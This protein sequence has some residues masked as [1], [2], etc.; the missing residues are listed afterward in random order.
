MRTTLLFLITMGSPWGTLLADAAGQ[1]GRKNIVLIAGIKS[2]GPEGNGIHDY[3]WSARLIRT[4]L[5]NSNVRHKVN[6]SMHLAGWPQ[7]ERL[8]HNA[9]AMMIIS[10]GRDGDIGREAPHLTTPERVRLVEAMVKRVCGVA[11]FH[12]STFAPDALGEK[13]IDWYGGYFDWETDGKRAWY[14]DITTIQAEVSPASGQHPVLRGVKPFTIREEFYYDIR[15]RPGDDGWVPVWSVKALPATKSQ[16]DV[17]AWA[18]ERESGSRGFAT[19]CGHFYANWQDANFR[20]TILN[21]LA[22]SAHVPIPDDGVESEFFSHAQIA[23][24]LREPDLVDVT[25]S[26]AGTADEDVYANEPYWYKPGHPLKPAEARAI[27]VL[28]G[29]EV[30]KV[31]TVPDEWGS[32]TAITVD[33]RG[34]LICAAQHEPGLYRLMSSDAGERSSP[35][36]FEKLKGVAQRMGWSHGLLSAFDSLYVTV[37]EGNDVVSGG[38][39]RLRDTD[40]DD[41]Y[42]EVTKLFE[43]NLSGEHGPHNIVV[44]PDGQSL[45]MI[46]GN[47]TRLPSGISRR[48]ATSTKGIDHLMPPGYDSSQ[49]SPSGFVVR[50]RPDGSDLELVCT[51]LRNSFDLAFN[52][53]GDLF[54]FDSDMEW[55]L[56][57][58]WYRPTRICHLVT[59]G[60]FGWRGDA[61]IWPEYFEDSVAPVV[62]VGPASPTGVVFGYAAKFPARYQRALYACDWT[63]ATIHA[64]HFEPHGGTYRGKV[65]EFLGGNG[66]PVTDLVIGADGAMYFVVGGRRLG[67][68]LYRVRYVGDEPTERAPAA[69]MEGSAAELHRSRRRLEEFHGKRDEKA[70]ETAG[71]YLG[72]DDRAIRFAARVAIESQL[73]QAWRQRV[74]NESRVRSKINGLIA[75]ARQ[76]APGNQPE[77]IASLGEIDT[78]RLSADQM[79]GMLRAL[80]LALARGEDEVRSQH[81]GVLQKLRARFP[82]ENPRVNRE[83]SRLLCYLGDRSM[84]GPVLEGMADDEGSRPA[85]GSGNF[86][87]NKKYGEAI[88]DMLQAAPLVDRMHFAQ[89]LLWIDGGWTEEQR[90]EY[91]RLIAD[92]AAHSK[93]GHW[94]VEFWNRIREIALDQMPDDQRKEYE[95]IGA[96]YATLFVE[97]DLPQPKGPGKKWGLDELLAAV[98][99]R[100]RDRDYQDGKK[101]YSAARCV[102]CHRFNGEG[103]SAGPDLSSI[104]QRFTVRD[105][106]DAT[107]NPSKAVS[108]QYRVSII[109]TND[110]R[111]LSGQVVSRDNE[112][113]SIATNLRR[114]SQTTSIGLSDIDAEHPTTISTMPED[115]LNPLNLDEVLNLLA[116]LISGGD[117]KH[118][119]F[120][121]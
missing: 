67:S 44:G 35:L 93:G 80:E 102:S 60:E 82:H 101:M 6:V 3:A 83:L 19:T 11:T 20:K 8:L 29:F 48:Y 85:L 7:D 97:Q 21:G 14:S 64:I 49:Y 109:L 95:A 32:W 74:L 25:E 52:Q 4:M 37:S 42:D 108:D 73:V 58:P 38:V 36:Q 92:G 59:G 120:R 86:A 121:Q 75:L 31:F 69:A 12:F 115:S 28:P 63:F 66:L 17:V 112:R 55:D 81:E 61:A 111:T 96:T 110:G 77:V 53:L 72:H 13:A 50:F 103:S 117:N 1:D 90:A 10:D 71:A 40:G 113:L 88:R 22:W 70:V 99:D 89:M 18:V 27:R 84:I 106:L 33:H 43:L 57:A 116:Y 51:G 39:Y 24:H 9:D 98:E 94:Y 68:A 26:D 76:D 118:P 105:I 23:R 34:R 30:E 87:R 46:C 104:G 2:H 15:F 56:G 41:Q 114:P 5:E 91:F 100:L 54:T 107:V 47:G 62:N 78:T 45:Y 79:L 65:E 16:G 119:V